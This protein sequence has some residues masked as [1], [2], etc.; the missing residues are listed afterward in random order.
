ML[1]RLLPV[2]SVLSLSAL[3]AEARLWMTK[4]QCA[5]KYRMVPTPD[6]APP[7]IVPGAEVV[8]Y[9]GMADASDFRIHVEF[10]NGYAVFIRYQSRSID[11][12][13]Q[14]V[15]L[16][17]NRGMTA[18]SVIVNDTQ[19]ALEE[20]LVAWST[21]EDFGDRRCWLGK[22]SDGK[23]NL[24]ATFY[25]NVNESY[26]AIGTQAALQAVKG[27]AA[28]A[29]KAPPPPAPAEPRVA[30]SESAPAQEYKGL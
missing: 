23:S 9:R 14:E 10:V 29:A 17:R 16:R 8:E 7:P 13:T 25:R 6:D 1:L 2:L 4:A 19:P 21:P 20:G 30:P 18:Q 28:A 24:H 11:E 5:E 3:T 26:L 15:I 22:S 12:R 27:Q